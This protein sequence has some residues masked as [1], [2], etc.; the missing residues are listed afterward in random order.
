MLVQKRQYMCEYGQNTYHKT[1]RGE[2]SIA[3]LTNPNLNINRYLNAKARENVG[4]SFEHIYD[5]A[6]YDD[7]KEYLN[8]FINP[9]EREMA[10][11]RREGY[12]YGNVGGSVHTQ[13]PFGRCQT[14][15]KTCGPLGCVKPRRKQDDFEYILY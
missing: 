10:I 1:E 11:R 14:S 13:P 6:I 2:E 5:D 7:R 9:A 3:T 8:R 4:H 12:L 15:K